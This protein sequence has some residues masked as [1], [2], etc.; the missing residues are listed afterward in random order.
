LRTFSRTLFLAAAVVI[1]SASLLQAQESDVLVTKSGPAQS[2]AN[3][4]VSYS[5]AV[6][7]LGP[8]DAVTV[9]LTDAIPAGMAFLS[10]TQDSGPLFVC[11]T[12]A[13]GDTSGSISCTIATLAAGSTASFTFVFHIP[14]GTAPSTFFVNTAT[15]SSPTDPNSENDSATAVTATPPPPQADLSVAKSGPA[16]AGPDTDVVYTITLLNS[17]PDDATKVNL[18]DILPGT[19]TFVSFVQNSG[20]ALSC[21]TPGGGSGGTV[22]CSTLT[23]AAGA[24]ATFTLTTHIPP[25]TTGTFV[26]T[27][28]VTSQ[29][30]PNSENDSS[31]SSLSVSAADAG[32]TK[33]GS[34]SVV[35]GTNISYTITVS[36]SGP[37]AAQDVTLDDVL[38]PNTTFVSLTQNTGPA[39]ACTTPIVGAN[40]AVSCNFIALGNGASAQ[41]T[42]VVEAGNTT[43]VSNT[44]TVT[45]ISSDN[46]PSN[47][48]ATFVT[49]VTPSAD[50]SVTKSGPAAV[51][52]GTN[53]TYTVTVANGGPSDASGVSLTDTLPANTTFV[54]ETQPT[55][56]A[57]N[58]VTPAAGAGGTITC[59]IAMFLS[60]DTA[61][62]SFTLQV[63][64]SAANGSTIAN[65]ADVSATTQ[66]P[67]NGN[68]SSTTTATVADT[69]DVTVT[70]SG[71]PSVVAGSNATYAVTVTNNGP[72]DAATVTLT[73]VL[74]PDTTFVSET[75][76]SGPTF[77]CTTPAL[78]APGTITC[79]IASLPTGTSA[80]FT[81]VLRVAPQATGTVA[82]TATVTSP[83]DSTPGNNAGTATAA[84]AANA[85][86]PTLSMFA[87]ALMAL[88]LVGIG[89]FVRS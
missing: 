22:S 49:T 79:T 76:T 1:G 55:G 6:T 68:N 56:P 46:N 34:A 80:A 62:F 69:A 45:T 89:L 20:P 24:P 9:T 39:A 2:A 42:L 67:D 47:D 37:D 35:A 40:G 4:D 65:T 83:S 52:A 26:N 77:A 38:P 88:A 11:T 14:T 78:D 29:N 17:G 10:S 25:A 53:V 31:S 85:G 71:P 43:S 66:D 51:A 63:A 36:N 61:T 7:N 59:S 73:D 41:F 54:S 44:A 28:T 84:I 72:A 30:D 16:G 3:T 75:Q 74:P 58:C 81:I 18:K 13:A 87:M 64:P 15:V 57:F 86:V 12:P 82:N 27:A 32:V 21:T 8:F 48:S 50:V 5:V 70:K 23:F 19:M 60:G 33:T